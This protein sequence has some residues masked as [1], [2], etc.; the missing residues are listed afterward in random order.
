MKNLISFLIIVMVASST[1]KA[2]CGPSQNIVVDVG[3]PALIHGAGFSEM[4]QTFTAPCNGAV[5]AITIIFSNV[6]VPSTGVLRIY[7][8]AQ[9]TTVLGSSTTVNIPTVNGPILIPLLTPANVIGGNQYTFGF[10]EF[11]S[12]TIGYL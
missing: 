2:Q 3:A 10:E 7:D 8:G 5:E 4:G 1:I 9:G 12:E 6:A 11:N